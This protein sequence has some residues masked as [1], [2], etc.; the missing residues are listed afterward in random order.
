MS[1]AHHPY[2]DARLLSISGQL[3]KSLEGIKK[4]QEQTGGVAA[5]CGSYV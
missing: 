4:T 3:G 1:L 5:L 2:K